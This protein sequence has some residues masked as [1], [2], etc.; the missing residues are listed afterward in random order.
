MR[1]LSS[2]WQ[3][4]RTESAYV[5]EQESRNVWKVRLDPETATVVGPPVQITAGSKNSEIPRASP[6]NQRIVYQIMPD[7][8]LAIIKTDGTEYRRLTQDS[9]R[10]RIAAWS[11][12]GERIAFYSDRS[13]SYEIWTIK[14][15]GSDLTQLTNTPGQS[16]NY[17]S[18]SPDGS[19]LAFFN[20]SE[21]QS[22]I[23]N[24]NESWTEQQP[25]TL[26]PYVGETDRFEAVSWSPDGLWLAGIGTSSNGNPPEVVVYSLESEEYRGLA[27]TTEAPSPMWLPDS[28]RVLYLWEG[29]ICVVD[30]V[31]GSVQ[32]VL[33]NPH[34]RLFERASLFSLSHDGCWIYFTAVEEQADIWMLTLNEE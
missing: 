30:R 4:T 25:A 27:T 33:D 8:D 13:E 31:S 5:E 2:R 11:P 23:F 7:E 28:R 26:P 34:E 18:W 20:R 17:P 6:D 19:Q 29:H 24:P 14:P 32:E 21:G 1:A 15:D 22:Y 10:N 3:A 9:H 16:V 12:D